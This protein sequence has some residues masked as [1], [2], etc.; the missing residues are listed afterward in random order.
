[1]TS[2]LMT[3]IVEDM[4]VDTVEDVT[5]VT[6]SMTA[7]TAVE[8]GAPNVVAKNELSLPRQMTNNKCLL[9]IGLS[10]FSIPLFP[11]IFLSF[12]FGDFCNN[13]IFCAIEL[14]KIF[15]IGFPYKAC[16]GGLPG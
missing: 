16:F 10:L 15:Y 2:I 3:L 6:A 4:G 9:F 13:D 1:M 12:L 5:A 14:I 8:D 11:Y 7:M